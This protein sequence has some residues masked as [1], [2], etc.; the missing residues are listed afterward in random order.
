MIVCKTLGGASGFTNMANKVV[1]KACI[2]SLGQQGPPEL[3]AERLTGCH[4]G[5]GALNSHSYDTITVCWSIK[6]KQI[7][8][9]A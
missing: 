3:V 4:C 2:L 8:Q 6:N 9:E 7:S 5:G 1:P